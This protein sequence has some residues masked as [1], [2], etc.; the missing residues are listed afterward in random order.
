MAS[1]DPATDFVRRSLERHALDAFFKSADDAVKNYA[2][3]RHNGA[4]TFGIQLYDNRSSRLEEIARRSDNSFEIV[5]LGG[6]DQHNHGNPTL[7]VR[8]QQEH[9]LIVVH[10]YNAK[11][12]YLLPSPNCAQTAKR[13]ATA[14][15]PELF[16][17]E[18][19]PMFHR[20]VGVV[21]TP[22]NGLEKI[23]VGELFR[24]QPGKETFRL[25]GRTEIDLTKYEHE[26]A[27]QQGGVP[28][29]P[30]EEPNL[31]LVKSGAGDAATGDT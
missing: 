14:D 22:D 8:H 26:P 13:H 5:N 29:E 15:H 28:P 25:K 7:A 18:S 21:A 20:H 31:S 24:T 16:P 3:S 10:I 1:S 11:E 19:E 27:S 12:P 6:E 9:G 2:A 23:V 30:E 17:D 4:L